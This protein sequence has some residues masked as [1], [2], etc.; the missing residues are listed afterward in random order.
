MADEIVDMNGNPPQEARP[1]TSEELLERY[2]DAKS[3]DHA[4]ELYRRDKEGVAAQE[5]LSEDAQRAAEQRA[6]FMAHPHTQLSKIAADLRAP[7]ATS[8]DVNT[9][10]AYISAALQRLVQLSLQHTQPPENPDE[11]RRPAEGTEAQGTA[12]N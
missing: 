10:L 9:K 6:A 8:G 2:P 4:W 5:G 1:P 12:G 7:A 11:V 3:P